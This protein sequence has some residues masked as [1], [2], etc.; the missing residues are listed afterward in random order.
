MQK[1]IEHVFV[2]MTGNTSHI[3]K[4]DMAFGVN[5]TE[6]NTFTRQCPYQACSFSTWLDQGIAQTRT[7]KPMTNG[8]V[9][10]N[11]PA[12]I[13]LPDLS[14]ILSALASTFAGFQSR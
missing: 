6:Y 11:I 14:S 8:S 4:K 13:Y 12:I 10:K 7:T 5:H 9:P 1:V 3:A 2:R